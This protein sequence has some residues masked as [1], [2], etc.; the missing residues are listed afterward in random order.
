MTTSRGKSPLK[1][2]M[3]TQYLSAVEENPTYKN[4]KPALSRIMGD[5]HQSQNLMDNSRSLVH[6]M[7]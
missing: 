5:L 1:E 4:M 6:L 3:Y 7:A 2:N